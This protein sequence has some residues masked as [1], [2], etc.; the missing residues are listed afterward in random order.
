MLL[1][2][3]VEQAVR[4]HKLKHLLAGLLSR[5]HRDELAQR[6]R[7]AQLLVA[8]YSYRG[9]EDATRASSKTIAAVDRWLRQGNRHYR[10]LYPLRHKRRYRHRGRPADAPRPI[11]PFNYRGQVAALFGL[12]SR[13]H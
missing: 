1:A 6:L 3:C 2:A 13:Q 8:G 11:F 7:I 5:G 4:H 9:I 12:D 10:R